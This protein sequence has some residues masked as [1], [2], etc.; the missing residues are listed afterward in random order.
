MQIRTANFH[1]HFKTQF[2]NAI[3]DCGEHFAAS[4]ESVETLYYLHLHSLHYEHNRTFRFSADSK[5]F[6]DLKVSTGNWS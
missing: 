6:L 3:A 2:F 4:L 1:F 5:V